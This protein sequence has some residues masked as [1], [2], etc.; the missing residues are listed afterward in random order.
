M[1]IIIIHP[2]FI[3]YDSIKIIPVVF[4]SQVLNP[5]LDMR[6]VKLTVWKSGGDMKLFYKI[7]D[8]TEP[9]D[10]DEQ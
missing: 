10:N 1:C 3:V 5:L 8:L 6:T 9:S 7:K 2:I 4:P